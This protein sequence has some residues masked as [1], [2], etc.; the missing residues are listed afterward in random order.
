MQPHRRS[1]LAALIAVIFTYSVAPVPELSAQ[2]AGA[3]AA[4]PAEDA[5]PAKETAME[6]S[7]P[8]SWGEAI[9]WRSIGPANMGGRIT[10]IAVYE[11]DPSIWWVS[12]AS[13]G[14]LKT[15][16]NGVTFEHQFDD[17]A[18]VS[19]GDV[20]VA[21]S[22]PNIVWVGTGESNPRNSVSWGNGVYKSTDGGDTWKH[23]GLEESYQ[24]GQVA[25]HPTNPEIVYVGALGRLW[26]PNEERG[27]FKTTDGGETWEKVFFLDDRTGVIEIKMQPGNPDTLL[28]CAYERKRDGQ[29]TNDPAVKFGEQS[30]IYKTTD[31]GKSW[32]RITRGLPS[33]QMGRIGIDWY[34][35]ESNVVYAMVETE[36]IG[37]EPENAPYAGLTGEDADVGARLTAVVDDGP[38][39]KAGLEVGDIV[40]SVDDA[41]VHSYGDLQAA[42]RRHVAGET[43]TLVVSRNRETVQVELALAKRPEPEEGAAGEN[44][45][46]GGGP[47]GG[48]PGGGG[49]GGGARNPFTGTLGGQ[50]ENMQGQQGESE[51]EYGGLYVSEDAGES[52]R[53]INTVNPRPMYYS[54]VRVDPQDR[55]HVFVLGTSLYRSKDGGSHFSGDG[56][57]G[58]IH[59]DHHALWL[60]PRDGRHQILGNDG[61]F[62]VTYD[63]MDHWEHHN[64][65][66]I[67][68]FYHVAVGSRRDYNV[69]GGLQDNG[70]WGGPSRVR[71]G[72]G[73]ANWHWLS[74]GGGDGFVCRVDADDPNLVY[75]E[76]QNG[77][78]GRRNLATGEGGQIRPEAPRG[79]RYRFNWRTPFILSEHNPKIYYV[80][81]N[82]VFRSLEEGSELRAISPELT[83]TDWGSATALAESPRDPDVLYAGTDDG[84]LW[85]TKNGGH[86]W[87]ALSFPLPPAPPDVVQGARVFYNLAP[88]AEVP[89]TQSQ[90]I[91]DDD[92]PPAPPINPRRQQM[93]DRLK[94]YDENGDGKISKSEVPEEVAGRM[95]DRVDTNS[96]GVIDTKELDAYARRPSGQGRG[97]PGGGEP[98]TGPPGGRDGSAAGDAPAAG[99]APPESGEGAGRRRGGRR[100]GGAD[101]PAA[102]AEPREVDVRSN[103]PELVDGPRWVSEIVASRYADGRVYLTLDGHRSDDDRP[104]VFASENYGETWKSIQGNLADSAGSTR[105]IAEDIQN[106]NILYLGTEFAGWVSIDRGETWTEFAGLPTVAVH[107]F[108]QHPT[109]GEIVAATHGRSL[110]IAD[111]TALRQM[112]KKTSSE[113]AKLFRPNHGVLWRNE[114]RTGV[115]RGFVGKNPPSG[116]QIVYSIGSE[117][118]GEAV[119]TITNLAGETLATLEA[120]TDRGLHSTFW[121]LRR[122]PRRGA[123]GR[124]AGGRGGGGGQFRG[125]RFGPLV[126]PGEYKV[127]LEVDGVRQ[128]QS[129]VVNIDPAY[130]DPTW[131]E[132]EYLEEQFSPTDE[133]EEGDEG[134]ERDI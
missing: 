7:L 64:Q 90:V 24:T 15:T 54:R 68:Q 113:S 36:K 108:A 13:G 92:D 20:A 119:L 102:E 89:Q 30:G 28:A 53:R 22:D 125:G 78:M 11:A 29:D 55:N 66:A 19:I 14:L 5:A 124:G 74:I 72:S 58:G 88:D 2:E 37:Q 121:D 79:T 77:G 106:E 62:Y 104:L 120:S 3:E 109:A 70:S 69:Y 93:I 116:A 48:G 82:L 110:W 100:G 131:L 27:V 98:G 103:L 31:G 39:A 50:R 73:P 35:K 105:C 129:L 43:A 4:A 123:Q 107:G 71:N 33:V 44:G 134:G 42:I 17:Q 46:R 130:P 47:G 52:W 51:H 12:S 57:S 67:G 38:T 26:G 117:R 65:M 56:G 86:D 10:S 21:Q 126:Q 25:I 81:A 83:P 84:A 60:D 40:V 16:N 115:A 63:R 23:M 61:G 32:R 18:T 59:V 112:T 91:D 128:E 111:V 118:V 34:R 96:D 8:A 76:S 6:S 114:P 122:T 80:G 127:V 9:S 41:I 45:G 97:R 95:F 1:L 101:D 99:G 94:G 75:F 132:Y 49:R 133:D 85:M 87:I